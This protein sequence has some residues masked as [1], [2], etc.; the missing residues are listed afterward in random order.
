M[1]ACDKYSSPLMPTTVHPSRMPSDMAWPVL[2]KTKER[3]IVNAGDGGGGGEGG[4]GKGYGG[5]GTEEGRGMGWGRGGRNH[6]LPA[7]VI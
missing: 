6:L 7:L 3:N 4:R 5:G 1:W 2:P